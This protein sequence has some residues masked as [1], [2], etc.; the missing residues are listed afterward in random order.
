M[1]L[2]NI[3]DYVSFSRKLKKK[4]C[5]SRHFVT[6]TSYTKKCTNLITGCFDIL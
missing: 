6:F 5:F 1:E 4:V 3:S 2:T